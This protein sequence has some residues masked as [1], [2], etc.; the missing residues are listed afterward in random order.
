MGSVDQ[1]PALVHRGMVEQPVHRSLPGPRERIL[2]FSN[3]LGDMDMNR[4][5]PGQLAHRG[6]F[7]RRDCSQAMGRNTEQ[8]AVEPNDRLGAGFVSRPKVSTSQMK[9]RCPSV[10]GSPPKLAWA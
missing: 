4:A 6:Q 1:A 2:D 8:G 7:I 10:G 3:L 9:R 5:G